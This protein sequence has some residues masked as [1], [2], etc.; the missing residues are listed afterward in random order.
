M[1][2]AIWRV[3]LAL[4]IVSNVPPDERPLV[5]TDLKSIST[6][7]Q[8]QLLAAISTTQAA[9]VDGVRTMTSTMTASMPAMAKVPAMPGMDKLP[10]PADA[11]ELG[12][13][14]AE[15]LLAGQRDFAERL[16]AAMTPVTEVAKPKAAK[17]A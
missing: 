1:T 12:F 2:D 7:A 16:L 6:A 11:L 15:R 5:A 10:T 13:G 14:F 4:T 3:K 17:A 9:F 8:D